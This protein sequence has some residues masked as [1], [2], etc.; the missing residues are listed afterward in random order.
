[1]LL[2]R[3]KAKMTLKSQSG[4]LLELYD[5]GDDGE[6]KATGVKCERHSQLPQTTMDDKES[7]KQVKTKGDNLVWFIQ[8]LSTY[9]YRKEC[10][11]LATEQWDDYLERKGPKPNP[12]Y[13]SDFEQR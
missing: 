1:M 7:G 9:L 6:I 3:H 4:E 12:A 8:D 13:F 2:E 5:D 10:L 11:I